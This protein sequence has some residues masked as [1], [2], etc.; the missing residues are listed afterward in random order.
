[1]SQDQANIG[2]EVEAD[3][4]FSGTN[5]SSLFI[6]NPVPNASNDSGKSFTGDL[7]FASHSS[8]V[9][10]VSD[11]QD[12][13]P[14]SYHDTA[15]EHDYTDD[16]F[17]DEPQIDIPA[18]AGSSE[19]HTNTAANESL[20]SKSS[21]SSSIEE[22]LTR[23]LHRLSCDSEIEFQN[24]SFIDNT[25]NQFDLD[26]NLDD[27]K[28]SRP[29]DEPSF[30]LACKSHSPH[31]LTLGQTHYLT[32]KQIANRSA[33]DLNTSARV[34]ELTKQLTN[35]K[36]Q[37]RLY[38]KFLQDLIDTH[39]VDAGQLDVLHQ[40]WQTR[41]ISGSSSFASRGD[42]ALPDREIADI[43]IL[44]EDLHA[45]LEECQLKWKEADL[46]ASAMSEVL[47]AWGCEISLLLKE[48]GCEEEFDLNQQ[49][50]ELLKKAMPLLKA[51]FE[52]LA[53][54]KMEE[55]NVETELKEQFEK[56][57]LQDSAERTERS[58]S[59]I[60]NQKLSPDLLSESPTNLHP[61]DYFLLPAK[62][63]NPDAFNIYQS[64]IEELEREVNTLKNNSRQTTSPEMSGSAGDAKGA[65][66]CD[67]LQTI[68]KERDA[69]QEKFDQLFERL[70]DV[71]QNSENK[72]NSLTNRLNSQKQEM[73]SLRTA[74]LNFDNIQRD[75]EVNVEKQRVLTSEK[76]KLSYQVEALQKDKLSL[77]YTIDNLTEKLQ[78]A[79]TLGSPH[80]K[81]NQST[82]SN[83]ASRSFEELFSSDVFYFQKLLTS[84][85]K[86]ADDKSLVDPTR[87][88]ESIMPYRTKLLSQTSEAIN[89]ALGYHS[90][91]SGFFAKAVDVIVKD[92]IRLL[93]KQDEDKIKHEARIDELN[94]RVARLEKELQSGKE[95]IPG[96][97][98]L[99]IEELTNRWKAER[100]ARVSENKAAKRRLN[101]LRQSTQ[102][103]I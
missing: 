18:S 36:I 67:K 57:R 88:L 53:A 24:S 51:S 23:Y 71:Q 78:K 38:E 3:L 21:H 45:S 96:E 14:K 49:P 56:L 39:N 9:T 43:S 81:I 27:H 62:S 66:S 29:P 86:I 58:K 31:K 89:F 52:S 8:R 98:Q 99:R 11:L 16:E 77:Q 30:W 100:E 84:F 91:V 42:E 12:M 74:A 61:G 25:E 47:R 28:A 95:N 15:S 94:E 32:Q 10:S 55:V 68:Q 7:K 6:T 80:R 79:S 1:M 85:N 60:S 48:L 19:E 69:L 73:L 75:L 103:F 26:I 22:E 17:D 82:E 76:I 102:Q 13:H 44:V 70:Q 59:Q 92:H 87:K 93:L 35:C 97:S 37:L 90:S 2:P 65:Q 33:A 5:D 83:L 34:A 4:D 54:K 41:S 72:I 40:Q 20:F 63:L 50:D 64:R 101:E 46:K